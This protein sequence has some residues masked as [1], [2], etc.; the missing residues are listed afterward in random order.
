[1]HWNIIMFSLCLWKNNKIKL[2]LSLS[3]RPHLYTFQ[4]PYVM[5]WVVSLRERPEWSIC[6]EGIFALYHGSCTRCSSDPPGSIFIQFEPGDVL[7]LVRS[8]LMSSFS[9]QYNSMGLSLSW[10]RKPFV[11]ID[12]SD[13]KKNSTFGCSHTLMSDIYFS[14]WFSLVP[15]PDFI[16]FTF[17]LSSGNIY[18]LFPMYW[19]GKRM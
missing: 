11:K 19:W 12:E 3:L 4:K 5:K 17:S 9:D 10:G 1:M 16:S 8:L 7:S 6:F 18:W 14:D 2:S 13:K 15:L